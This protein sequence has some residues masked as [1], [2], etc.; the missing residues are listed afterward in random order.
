MIIQYFTPV[1]ALS[2]K[3]EYAYLHWLF[4]QTLTSLT[5]SFV[6]E[7]HAF[8]AHTRLTAEVKG[9]FGKLEGECTFRRAS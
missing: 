7:I 8:V 9:G 2:S 1:P 6:L 5:L 4:S 3:P